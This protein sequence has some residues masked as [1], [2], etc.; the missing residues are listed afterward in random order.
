MPD[1]QQVL[2]SPGTRAS[3]GALKRRISR[4]MHKEGPKPPETKSNPGKRARRDPPLRG[5]WVC[6]TSRQVFGCLNPKTAIL[7]FLSGKMLIFFFSPKE[8]T[9]EYK[10][11]ASYWWFHEGG[12][13]T[14]LS[15][16]YQILQRSTK[17]DLRENFPLSR[18]L[19][20]PQSHRDPAEP[21]LAAL[22][23]FLKTTS[24]ALPNHLKQ[25]DLCWTKH[26]FCPSIFSITPSGPSQATAVHTLHFS[27]PESVFY[28]FLIWVSQLKHQDKLF[29]PH[30]T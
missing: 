20:V 3:H 29:T 14:F 25:K 11:E 22:C 23:I 1:P 18:E 6:C 10:A 28:F 7:M 21:R 12:K 30:S 5:C 17:S 2:G 26:W 9:G 27:H 24:S 19:R 4:W 16:F 8:N 15:Q 13:G